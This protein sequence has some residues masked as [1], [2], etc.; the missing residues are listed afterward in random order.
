MKVSDQAWRISVV[1]ALHAAPLPG[2]ALP[3]K[4]LLQ[5]GRHGRTFFPALAIGR[6][7][8]ERYEREVVLVVTQRGIEM[9]LV[10]Q[11]PDLPSKRCAWPD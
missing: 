6:M 5:A 11:R 2:K 4:L 10:P 7:A 3:V 1:G 8:F 9:K